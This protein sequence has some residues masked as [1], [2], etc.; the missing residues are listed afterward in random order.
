M[1]QLA[2]PWS[3]TMTLNEVAFPTPEEI[4]RRMGLGDLRIGRHFL[5]G[6]TGELTGSVSVCTLWHAEVVPSFHPRIAVAVA[7]AVGE[8]FRDSCSPDFVKA[9]MATPEITQ[10]IATDSDPML[11]ALNHID[12]FCNDHMPPSLGGIAY[13]I[14]FQTMHLHGTLQFGNPAHRC[15]RSIE[16]ALL[17]VAQKV[18]AQSGEP[19]LR[20]VVDAWR[21]F[22]QDKPGN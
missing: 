1:D 10:V 3:K 19:K 15:L 21:E 11:R 6:T 5:R 14:T 18:A 2:A 9:V 22:V 16:N 20:E 13:T 12:L 4:A 8:P 17:S 7:T